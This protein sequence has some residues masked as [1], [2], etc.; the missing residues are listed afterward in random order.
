MPDPASRA[1]GT[2]VTQRRRRATAPALA[3][4]RH[5]HHSCHANCEVKLRAFMPASL[6]EK[7]VTASPASPLATITGRRPAPTENMPA[8]TP[9]RC[10]RPLTMSILQTQSPPASRI[11]R[12]CPPC[13]SPLRRLRYRRR[14]HH[15]ADARL[16]A[17]RCQPR[18]TF[19]MLHGPQQNQY[20]RQWSFWNTGS[21]SRL[22]LP[23]FSRLTALPRAGIPVPVRPPRHGT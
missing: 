16:S 17:A 3:R 19:A 15:T 8:D 20:H 22:R 7:N 1:G 4:C 5:H 6:F 9:R 12:R 2:P 23:L 10:R 21:R 13:R 14:H 11:R 18:C